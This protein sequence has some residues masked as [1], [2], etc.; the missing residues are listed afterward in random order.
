MLPKP[1][2]ITTRL[3]EM[4]YPLLNKMDQRFLFSRIMF[5]FN[6]VEIKSIQ[7]YLPIK[8]LT[9]ALQSCILWDVREQTL[10]NINTM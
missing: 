1:R 5:Y 6:E 10:R 9:V 4:K 3:I 8:V 2:T 7:K